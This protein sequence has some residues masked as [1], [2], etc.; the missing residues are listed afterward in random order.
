MVFKKA[1]KKEQIR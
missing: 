1:D